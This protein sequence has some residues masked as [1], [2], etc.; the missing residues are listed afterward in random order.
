MKKIAIIYG[1]SRPSSNAGENT[2]NWFLE[3]LNI[4]EDVAVS[5]INLGDENL[6]LISEEKPPI[7]NS[8]ELEPTINWGNKIG[9]FDGF[10]F[11]VAEYNLGY[12]PILKNAIDTIFKEWN[13][14]SAALISYG[15]YPTS[16][17]AEQLKTVLSPFKMKISSKTLHISPIR[18]AFNEN[19]KL[20]ESKVKGDSPQEI[21]ND[22]LSSIE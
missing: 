19:R 8:Y 9:Q 2:A 16:T 17:A 12:T 7:A 5:K 6:P 1:S 4:P 21:L 22:V 13:E 18:D 20:D 11:V 14:K 10:I 3:S 15:S